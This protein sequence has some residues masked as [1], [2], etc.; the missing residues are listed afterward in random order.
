MADIQPDVVEQVAAEESSSESNKNLYEGIEEPK[1]EVETPESQ[2]PKVEDEKHIDKKGASYRIQE[3][4]EK[5]KAAEAKADSL[6]KQIEQLTASSQPQQSWDQLNQPLPT[7]DNGQVDA[8]EFEKRIL[9]KASA[10]AELQTARTQHVSRVNQE[11][12]SVME[13]YSVL[14]P[15]SEGYDKDLSESIAQASLAYVR[16]NP[17]ASLKKFVDG[18]MKPYA[19]AVSKQAGDMQEIIT[20]QAAETALRPGS[21]PKGEKRFEE[22]S[23]KEMEEKLGL[24]Y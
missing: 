16:Q 12:Q 10:I 20:K 4:N 21:A 13:E 1:G 18:L 11:A 2:E 23:L 24:V 17:T 3:L 7:D 19:K 8:A 9:A 15:D 6:A 5:A 22:L 14:N